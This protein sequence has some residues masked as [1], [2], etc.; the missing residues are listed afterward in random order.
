MLMCAALEV[1]YSS[2]FRAEVCRVDAFLCT[3][4][5]FCLE[6]TGGGDG[7]W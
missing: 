4:I 7:G 1:H 6:I 3:Y 5:D 2:I